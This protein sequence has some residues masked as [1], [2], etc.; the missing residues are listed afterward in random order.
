VYYIG[1]RRR[2]KDVILCSN[3]P[4]RSGGAEKKRIALAFIV[5]AV[6]PWVTGE[7][8]DIWPSPAAYGDLV[9]KRWKSFLIGWI[10]AA[11]GLEQLQRRAQNSEV[12][13]SPSYGISVTKWK[14]SA[15]WLQE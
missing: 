11:V 13:T 1:V 14:R 10:L 2:R 9:K 5:K 7:A 4:V 6:P 8:D 3:L 12:F 15:L